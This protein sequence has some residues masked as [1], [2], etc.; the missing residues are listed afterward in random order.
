MATIHRLTP[1]RRTG[2]RRSGRWQLGLQELTRDGGDLVGMVE[3]GRMPA[4]H[5]REAARG[6]QLGDAPTY[7]H[8]PERVFLAPDHL[9]R[10]LYGA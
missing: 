7:P 1:R 6:D 3:P 8:A 4:G 2:R 5:D 9:H 10:V